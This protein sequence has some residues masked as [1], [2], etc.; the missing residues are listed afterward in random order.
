[1]RRT[2]LDLPN[3]PNL[4][5][6]SLAL[7]YCATTMALA[8]ACDSLLPSEIQQSALLQ[9]LSNPLILCR[10]TAYLPVADVLALAGTC[11]AFRYLIR[12]T[13]QVFRYLD[14]RP[15]KSARVDVEGIDR[16]GETWR[17]VQ[18]DENL[19]EDE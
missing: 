16:G 1:M 4:A 10:T 5:A 17:N 15:F 12:E 13:P 3:Q 2:Q 19:T 18:L 8:R 9:L 11:R 14:L 6:L 7:A